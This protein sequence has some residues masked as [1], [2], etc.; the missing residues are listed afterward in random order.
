MSHIDTL[1]FLSVLSSTIYE[2][3]EFNNENGFDLS[4]RIDEE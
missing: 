3:M 4:A 1:E 2:A